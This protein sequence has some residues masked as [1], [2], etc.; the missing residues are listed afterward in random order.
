MNSLL[1]ADELRVKVAEDALKINAKTPMDFEW[2][3]LHYATQNSDLTQ[4]QIKNLDQ[5]KRINQEEKIIT[6]NESAKLSSAE[7]KTNDENLSDDGTGPKVW[8]GMGK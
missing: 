7:E 6:E 2:A 4:Q 3:N 5:L 1:L 8:E